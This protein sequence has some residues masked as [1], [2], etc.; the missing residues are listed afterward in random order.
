MSDEKKKLTTAEILALARKK[1]SEGGSAEAPS[2]EAGASGESSPADSESKPAAA[3]KSTADILAA[4]RAQG[5][6]KKESGDEPKPAA[7]KSTADILAAARKQGGGAKPSP[8]A[9][10]APKS[11]A[12]ILAA[13][14][15]QK[16]AAA[17]SS[18]SP[19]KAAPKG[20]APAKP[21]EAGDLPALKDMVAAVTEAKKSGAP[22]RPKVTPGK[23]V[24]GKPKLPKKAEKT[25]RRGFW[26]IFA[27]A[28]ITPFAFAWA[29]VS[30]IAGLWALGVARFM[31][32][33]MVLEL[34]SRF[35]VG[36]TSDFP[37]GTVSEKFK[38]SRGIW[39]V[40]T[41]QY[42]G[43]G[44]IYA[45][46]S[47]CTHLGCTPNWLEGEQKFKCPCHGSGFYI[48]GIN[49]EGPAPRPL[50]RVG[51]ELAPDGLLEVDKSVKFQEELGQW[52]DPKSY[53]LA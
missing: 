5:G 36:P 15:A 38:A 19:A 47:V 22:V 44:M 50:E 35:K 52:V 34:P 17:G 42:D 3:P 33:N 13:A 31:M 11:T 39:I 29:S 24:A 25:T 45:L 40:N 32:P 28:T 26:G 27:A 18:P 9:G 8:A 30:A 16:A 41:D 1:K 43:R 7:P 2:S 23:P 21:A 53:E 37:P 12:D 14:R 20:K 46:A 6:G 48:T 4:A 49:F 51:I 10:G